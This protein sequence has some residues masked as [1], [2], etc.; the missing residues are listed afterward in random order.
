MRYF[1]KREVELLVPCGNFEIFK[2][3]LNSGADA[4]YF[5]GKNFNMRLHRKDFNFTNDE[6]RTA[7]SLA[8]ENGKRV[9]ITVNN[10]LDE[11]DC[12]ALD[13]YLKV[14]E[15]IGPD[16]LIVQDLAV[17]ERVQALE[18]SLP[19]HASVM[20]NVHNLDMIRFLRAKGVSRVV[21]SRD[22]SLNTVK[23]FDAQ[24]D[25]ELEYFVHGD[26]CAVHGSQCH[27]SGL[28]FGK[29]SNRG[30]C[31]K[32]CRWHYTIDHALETVDTTYP[33]AV[34]DMYLYEHIP[35]LI[36]AG[37]VSFKIEGRMRDSAYLIPLI[38]SYS[39][40]IDRYI[41]DPICYNRRQDAET[42]FENRKRDFSTARAFGEPGLSYINE[43][44]E[45]TG[46]FYSTGK[47]F[48]NPVEEMAIS[49]VRTATLN[50]VFGSG[51]P[52]AALTVR[53]NDVEQAKV[54]LSCGVS[55]LYLSGEPIGGATPFTREAIRQLTRKKGATE[56]FYALPTMMTDAQVNH[57]VHYFDTDHMG[58][59]G[60]LV[61]HMGSA[62][63]FKALGLKCVGDYTLNAYNGTAVKCL[64]ASGIETVA[65]SLELGA[66]AL[67]AL[68]DS[69]PA[70]ELIAH[71]KPTVMYMDQ[72]LFKNLTVFEPIGADSKAVLYLVDDDGRRHPVYRDCF[73]KNHFTTTKPLCLMPLIES[74]GARVRYWRVEGATYT[75]ERLKACLELYQSVLN[76]ACDS[77]DAYKAL[78]ELEGE[79]S[80][81]ALN[82]D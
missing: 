23:S 79:P 49:P 24:S 62:E 34:K 77:K 81:F 11:G 46:K 54:A 31:M 68:T 53:V 71:G 17:V 13:D 18:L 5:G 76:G 10:L 39:D 12:G 25:M 28:L 70:L 43:R 57:Y 2:A 82:F 72:D 20:M 59:D 3:L 51:S 50:A 63:P 33:M 58:L 73:G 21:V 26:M 27:Y 75:P 32:P 37:V 66:D 74:L 42:L 41:E 29:S 45:G 55:R 65:A 48:S 9:Y 30:K 52:N 56:V 15:C 4:F 35:E 64:Q 6:M 38:Q 69:V 40:A 14:L 80:Y 78:V 36:D 67:K 44:Y 8:H 1:N 19:L 60:V 61:T 47:P 22:V 16:A 7:V